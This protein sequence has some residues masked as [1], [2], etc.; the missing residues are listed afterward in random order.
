MLLGWVGENTNA[1]SFP[2]NHT[3][4]QLQTTAV[5]TSRSGMNVAIRKI[6]ILTPSTGTINS[7]TRVMPQMMPSLRHF[8]PPLGKTQGTCVIRVLNTTQTCSTFALTTSAAT[9]GGTSFATL[10]TPSTPAP[11]LKWS[12][13]RP[14]AGCL[15]PHIRTIV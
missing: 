15:Q 1:S 7:L 4:V 2:A 10:T 9:P 5:T 8:D 3:S 6:N 13:G 11:A 12:S 14:Y